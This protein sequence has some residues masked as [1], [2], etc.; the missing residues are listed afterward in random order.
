MELNGTQW[1]SMELNG[2]QRNSMELNGTQWNSTELFLRFYGTIFLLYGLSKS[3]KISLL[4]IK[5]G[6]VK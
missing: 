3:M 6:G 5:L 1:N 4:S 2:T